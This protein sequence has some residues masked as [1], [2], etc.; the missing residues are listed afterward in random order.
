MYHMVEIGRIK[1]TASL[2]ELASLCETVVFYTNIASA[3]VKKQRS[4]CNRAQLTEKSGV[5]WL[6]VYHRLKGRVYQCYLLKQGTDPDRFEKIKTLTSKFD[7]VVER[8]PDE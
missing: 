1:R 4:M 7:V 6:S 8:F 2:D 3:T 5:E